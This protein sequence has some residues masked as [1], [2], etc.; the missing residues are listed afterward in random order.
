M[1]NIARFSSPTTATKV[2]R[3]CGKGSGCCFD[4]WILLEPMPDSLADKPKTRGP[5][6]SR[7]KDDETTALR[8]ARLLAHIGLV[9]FPAPS[10]VRMCERAK[11]VSGK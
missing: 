10:Y 8:T 1:K 4:M 11:E 9:W 5:G 2:D 3:R 7:R 6:N